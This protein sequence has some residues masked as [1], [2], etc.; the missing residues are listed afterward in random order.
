MQTITD[1][2]GLVDALGGNTAV[3]NA[4][5]DCTPVRVGQWKISNRIPPEYWQEII[6][7]AHSKGLDQITSDWLVATLRPRSNSS[8]QDAA[9]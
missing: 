6:A 8:A 2:R 4:L 9:A 1:H 5:T 7:A 3:A